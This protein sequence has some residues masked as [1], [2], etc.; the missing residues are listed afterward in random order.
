MVRVK[1]KKQELIFKV[2]A[3]KKN[4]FHFFK[5]N[6]EQYTLEVFFPV[7]I[8]VSSN[9]VQRSP[10]FFQ[11]FKIN[12]EEWRSDT[13]KFMSLSKVH[14]VSHDSS[15]MISYFLSVATILLFP[16]TSCT[17]TLTSKSSAFAPFPGT[18]VR[19]FSSLTLIVFFFRRTIT[20]LLFCILFFR[21]HK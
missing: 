1:D 10:S 16:S 18:F 20:P 13:S 2:G 14:P 3:E 17:T 6:L 15:V 4:S 8:N 7:K 21:L 5:I 9:S 19:Y 12:L 11:L